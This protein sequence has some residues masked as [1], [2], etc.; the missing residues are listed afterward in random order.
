MKYYHF[1]VTLEIAIPDSEYSEKLAKVKFKE[2]MEKAMSLSGVQAYNEV[3]FME[4]DL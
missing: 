4:V 3:A 2:A 1:T